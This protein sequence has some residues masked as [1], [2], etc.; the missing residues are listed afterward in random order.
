MINAPQADNGPTHDAKAPAEVA[1]MARSAEAVGMFWIMPGMVGTR[2]RTQ[3][4]ESVKSDITLLDR[5]MSGATVSV[6]ITEDKAG[7]TYTAITSVYRLLKHA[8][9]KRVLFLG[10]RKILANRQRANFVTTSHLM[11]VGCFQSYTPC[12]A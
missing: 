5:L 4:R 6:L 12:V 7:K 8:K 2:V 10:T 11:M 1:A 9:A 3:T